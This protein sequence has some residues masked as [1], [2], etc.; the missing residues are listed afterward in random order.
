MVGQIDEETSDRDVLLPKL[1]AS[2]DLDPVRSQCKAFGFQLDWD[3][4]GV[5][6]PNDSSTHLEIAGETD[7]VTTD[8]IEDGRASDCWAR[9]EWHQAGQEP[10]ERFQSSHGSGPSRQ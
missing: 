9:S 4:P 3:R 2:F 5:Y 8:P 1:D 6:E 10:W 7:R